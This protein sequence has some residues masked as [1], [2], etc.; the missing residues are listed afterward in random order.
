VGSHAS[1]G[2]RALVAGDDRR[3]HAPV[4]VVG[5]HLDAR[6]ADRPGAFR[7]GVARGVVDNED[8]VDEAGDPLQRCCDQALLVVR[9][10]DDCNRFAFQ[11]GS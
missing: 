8:P 3:S 10:D 9:R 5:D 1:L 6:V 11:H 7:G 2:E 4:A